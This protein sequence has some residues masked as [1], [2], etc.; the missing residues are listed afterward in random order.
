MLINIDFIVFIARFLASI[1]GVHHHITDLLAPGAKKCI[2]DII[3]QICA[4]AITHEYVKACGSPVIY[5]TEVK[6][7]SIWCVWWIV[8]NAFLT[9][10]ASYYTWV[11]TNMYDFVQSSRYPK[12][13]M[14]IVFLLLKLETCIPTVLRH[15][16]EGNCASKINAFP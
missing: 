2:Y 9:H 13:H 16:E 12:N 10:S 8:I 6:C 4:I 11:T 3:S 7:Y 15:T 14:L 5:N 1:G